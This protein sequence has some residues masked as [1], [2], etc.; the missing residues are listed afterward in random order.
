MKPLLRLIFLLF[1]ISSSGCKKLIE[2]KQE[3]M[4]MDAI[5]NGQWLVEQFHENGTDITPEFTSFTIQFYEDHSVKAM[6]ESD[7]TAGTWEPDVNNA[8]IS[9]SFPT[10][11]DPVKKFNGLWKIT[12]SEWTFVKAEMKTSSGRNILHLRKK[13]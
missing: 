8:S 7:I 10:A 9:A 12:D 3:S 2:K 11:A 1:V 6:R 13:S 5:V 4:V